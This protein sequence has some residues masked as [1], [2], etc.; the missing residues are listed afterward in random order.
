MKTIVKNEG[1]IS[2]YIFSDETEINLL[3]DRVEV[4]SP[5]ILVISDHNAQ[6]VTVYDN[7]TPPEDWR[8]WKYTFD[9]SEWALNP[10]YIEPG[11]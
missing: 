3:D 8:G 2:I 6:T 5:I 11:A 9:G 10:D 4:G 7:A 1:N